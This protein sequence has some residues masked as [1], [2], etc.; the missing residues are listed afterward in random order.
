MREKRSLSQQNS[1]EQRFQRSDVLYMD[2]EDQQKIRNFPAVSN[3]ILYNFQLQKE[4][5][6]DQLKFKCI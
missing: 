6:S 3:H 4:E 1:V 2:S 5:N